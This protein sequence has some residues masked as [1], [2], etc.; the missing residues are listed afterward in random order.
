[1]SVSRPRAHRLAGT[2]ALLEKL[3]AYEAVH[4]IRS[5]RDLKNRLDLDRRCFASSIRACPTSR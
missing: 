5:W 4:A 3:V 2:A 1:M